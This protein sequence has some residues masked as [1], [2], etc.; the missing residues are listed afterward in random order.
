MPAYATCV[1]MTLLCNAIIWYPLFR[2]T[3]EFSSRWNFT[4]SASSF[5]MSMAWFGF[6]GALFVSAA[7][8]LILMSTYGS[9]QYLDIVGTHCGADT[10]NTLGSLSAMFGERP[11]MIFWRLGMMGAMPLIITTSV[12]LFLRQKQSGSPLPLATF[13]AS[14]VE[15]ASLAV[16][17]VCKAWPS[18][19]WL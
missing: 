15:N 16:L 10:V 8:S 11:N 9:D 2:W 5:K 14:S 18:D 12:L 1:F 17:T 6:A 7:L 19:V 13:I 3:K 4:K